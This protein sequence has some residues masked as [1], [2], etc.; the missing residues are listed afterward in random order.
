MGQELARSENPTVIALIPARAGSKRVPGKNIRQLA[1]HPLIAYTIAAAIQSQV[2]AAV[3]VSTD[4]EEI[5]EIARYYGAEVPFLRSPAYS[6]DNSPDLEWIEELL[7]RLK[8]S[9]R[10]YDCFSI[11]RPTSPF[12][13]PETIQRAWQ[14]FRSRPDSID[15]LRA[16][17][18]CQQHPGKMWVLQGQTMKPLL[19]NDDPDGVPWHSTPYQALPEVYVQ[20]ASLEIAWCRVVL[21]GRTIAGDAIAPFLTQGYEGVDINDAKDWW[22][23][24]YLLQQKA[25]Q[26]PAVSQAPRQAID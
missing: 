12:R 8:S 2:F 17:E 11:L 24:E 3:M 10:F 7:L 20:N 9:D 18:K 5:A 25:V 14:E 6:G 4:S 13:Q 1:G 26:L 16:V 21:E 15:S 22:Y 23:V 19:T